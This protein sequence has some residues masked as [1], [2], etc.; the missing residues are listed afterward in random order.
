MLFHELFMLLWTNLM[1]M[2]RRSCLCEICDFKKFLAKNQENHAE[3]SRGIKGPA[4]GQAMRVM[5]PQCVV[6]QDHT[7]Y[8]CGLLCFSIVC[9]LEGSLA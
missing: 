3:P 4:K 2:V 7:T 9:P 5:C 8:L 6:P 1:I